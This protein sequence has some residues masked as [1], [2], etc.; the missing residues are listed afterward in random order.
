M[1]KKLASFA[2]LLLAPSILWAY[3]WPIR[4]A[5]GNFDGPLPVSA[6]S[7]DYRGSRWSPRFHRGIDIPANARTEVFSILSGTATTPRRTDYVVVGD[8]W[9]K[10]LGQRIRNGD[11]V[12][13]IRENSRN[14]TRIG[15][16]RD[17]GDPGP[18]QDHLHF[19]IG[20]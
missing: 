15:V 9:Y 12:T 18:R 17:Y 11:D 16:V 5:Q 1:K 19:Q 20:Y 3:P 6:T 2:F 7:G 8:Y 10:H 4:N 14:P 13:G